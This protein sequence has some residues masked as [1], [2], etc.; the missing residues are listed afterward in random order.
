LIEYDETS[1]A[2]LLAHELVYLPKT[3]RKVIFPFVLESAVT[4]SAMDVQGL[5]FRRCPDDA[6]AA[7]PICPTIGATTKVE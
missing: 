2:R 4:S 3:V 1:S 6:N 7:S 5:L